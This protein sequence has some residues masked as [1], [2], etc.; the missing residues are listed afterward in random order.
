MPRLFSKIDA[1]FT[2][3]NVGVAL[4]LDA[5]WKD[6]ESGGILVGERI[7]LKRAD[8]SEFPTYVFA[9]EGLNRGQRPRGV[10]I[11][12]PKGITE[13]SIGAVAEVWLEREDNNPVLFLAAH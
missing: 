8:G 7:R 10:A 5:S 2:I 3:S 12:L 4:C 11:R 9:L 13:Q 1:V 6:V